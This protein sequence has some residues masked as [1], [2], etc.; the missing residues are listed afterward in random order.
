MFSISLI[1][2]FWQPINLKI[3]WE[4]NQDVFPVLGGNLD[5]TEPDLGKQNCAKL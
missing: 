4:S 3:F 5:E 1:L 2:Y